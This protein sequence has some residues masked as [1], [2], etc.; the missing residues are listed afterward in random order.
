MYFTLFC[1]ESD[2]HF[3]KPTILKAYEA[4]EYDA[5]FVLTLH[6]G[7]VLVSHDIIFHVSRIEKLVLSL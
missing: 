4:Q 1:G 6:L 3:L 7:F 2:I 5:S